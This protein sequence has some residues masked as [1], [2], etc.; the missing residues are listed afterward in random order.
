[1]KARDELLIVPENKVVGGFVCPICLS[2]AIGK[3]WASHVK[4]CPD[5]GQH[6]KVD[7]KLFC[8]L[9]EKVAELPEEDKKKICEFQIYGG[10]DVKCA[11]YIAGIYKARLEKRLKDK[12]FEDAQLSFNDCLMK[13]SLEERIEQQAKVGEDGEDCVNA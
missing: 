2:V 9:E 12:S 4:Y 11:R 1:M 6:I 13:T 10:I 8:N 7:T 5:C 3:K